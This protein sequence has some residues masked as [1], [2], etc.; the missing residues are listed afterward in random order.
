MNWLAPILA[1]ALVV[2][3]PPPL[4]IAQRSV[5]ANAATQPAA[6]SA[7]IAGA[8]AQTVGNLPSA[9]A[10]PRELAGML[11]KQNEVRAKAG[12][13][14]LA[15]SSEIASEVKV[16]LAAPEA[17]SATGSRKMAI[18]KDLSFY[19]VGP[20]RRVDGVSQ[21]Q[22]LTASF[23][24]SEWNAAKA[25]YDVATGACRRIGECESYAR[26]VKPAARTV[27]CARVVCP[28]Q[29]QVWACRYDAPVA[30]KPKN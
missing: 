9:A 1:F 27:G 11:A 7:R 6:P 20:V 24:V 16:S 10:E 12:L 29:A 8:G 19:W 2:T 30:L 17:C 14:P 5:A 4:A 23:I 28:T 15:W 18:A 26:L 21:S 3:A 22:D 13:A 25:D